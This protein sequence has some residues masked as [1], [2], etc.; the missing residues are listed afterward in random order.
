MDEV[1]G[2][3]KCAQLESLDLSQNPVAAL[4]DYK[5]Q[6]RGALPKLDV[7]DSFNKA[8]DEVVSED[9]ESEEDEEDGEDDE[10]DDDEDED[11]DDEDEEG[12]EDQED[13][14]DED[15]EE[16]GEEEEEDKAVGSKRKAPTNGVAEGNDPEVPDAAKKRAVGERLK[17]DGLRS[18]Q[19]DGI[20]SV[21][22]KSVD[23]GKN[24][25]GEDGLLD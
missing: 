21:G 9:E 3:A 24:A 2:L 8:G 16:E 20:V 6:V 18:G 15:E 10:E 4:E 13:G 14:P 25:S 22:V 17:L 23:I 11:G 12:E 19:E 5:D 1:K 7:L